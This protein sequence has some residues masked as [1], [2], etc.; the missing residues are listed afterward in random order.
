MHRHKLTSRLICTLT[1]VA[2]LL[3]FGACDG[4][5]GPTSP[6]SVSTA[7]I[8]AAI[9]QA[10]NIARTNQGVPTLTLQEA[11]SQVAREHSRNM[12]DQGF[13]GHVNQDGQGLKQRLNA[14]GISYKAASENL[15][16]V[17]NAPDPAD[18]AFDLLVG[19]PDHEENILD[20]KFKQIG[21]GA[22]QSGNTYWV[23]Q[24]F[25]QP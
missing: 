1:G 13:F 2:A 3:L 23:T 24:I 25:I 5:G 12:R 9:F 17:T 7:E 10:T 18:V 11:I 6:I 4:S 20:P 21:V 8:E 22:A 19:S 14:A 16:Q 15:V